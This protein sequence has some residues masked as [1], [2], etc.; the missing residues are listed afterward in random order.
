MPD[1]NKDGG[2]VNIISSSSP[3]G[4]VGSGLDVSVGEGLGLS[5][6]GVSL[7]VTSGVGVSEG[8]GVSGVDVAGGVT[9]GD[10]VVAG[11]GVSGDGVSL[12]F[13]ILPLVSSVS[14]NNPNPWVN[15][16]TKANAR[17]STATP[18]MISGALLFFFAAAGAAGITA[19]TGAAGVSAGCV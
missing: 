12:L 3:N 13:A 4:P 7:G 15:S 8:D 10:G 17:T 18:A 19:A 5:G 14:P 1:G 9:S 16:P 2:M 11:G 6:V